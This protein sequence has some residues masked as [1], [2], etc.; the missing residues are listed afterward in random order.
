MQMVG[1]FRNISSYI[2]PRVGRE[3]AEQK[4]EEIISTIPTMATRVIG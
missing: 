4:R 3:E 2:L 1:L